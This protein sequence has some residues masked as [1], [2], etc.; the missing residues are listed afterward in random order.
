VFFISLFYVSTSLSNVPKSTCVTGQFI[1]S[2][3]FIFI[4]CFALFHACKLFH[5]IGTSVGYFEVCVFEY[6]GDFPDLLAVI[7]EGGPL[8]VYFFVIFVCFLFHFCPKFSYGMYW[9]VVT[10]RN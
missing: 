6:V 4:C 9:E 1:D 2:T 8:F 7:C 5:A 10:F 3:L